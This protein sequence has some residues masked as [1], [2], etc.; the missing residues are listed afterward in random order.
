MQ[1]CPEELHDGYSVKFITTYSKNREEWYVADIGSTLYGISTVPLYESLS[2]EH[3][4]YIF[5]QTELKTIIL[6]IDKLQKI[7]DLKAANKA[8]KLAN[9]ITIEDYTETHKRACEEYG[10]CL[11]SYQEII[12]CGKMNPKETIEPNEND[13]YTISYTSGTT[14][15]PKGVMLTHRNVISS[16][17]IL[18]NKIRPTPD[19]IHISFLPGAHMYEK[20]IA[21]I[22]ILTGGSIGFYRG[23]SLT[24][25]NDILL[26]K[27]TILFCVPRILNKFYD[28]INAT[29]DAESENKKRIIHNAIR[30]KLENLRKYGD[31]THIIYDALLFKKMKALIGGRVRLLMSG[32]APMAID[33]LDFLK[34]IFSS[35]I[36]DGY[37][38]TEVSGACFCTTPDDYV[39]GQAG[40]IVESLAGKLVDVPEMNYRINGVNINGESWRCGEVCLKG[41]GLF[42]KYFK[43]PISTS[44][45]LDSEGWF[46][47]GDIARLRDNGSISVIDRKKSLFKLSQGE[48]ISP[49]RVEN[50]Y[51]QSKFTSFVFAYGD[52]LKDFLVAIIVPDKNV[53]E[54]LAQKEGIEG[55]W[56]EI[57]RDLK[58]RDIIMEDLHHVGKTLGLYGHE[59]AKRIYLHETMITPDTGLLTPTFKMKRYELKMHFQN[60]IDQLYNS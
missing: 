38:L 50:I 41:V 8:S 49:E 22:F 57:C 10:L 42:P 23:D 5:A 33:I 46:H 60:I 21:N 48:Y 27:P 55:N 11:Y 7:I 43:N 52:S 19:D 39:S 47:T 30:E 12:Q 29:I 13:L 34:V 56:E 25:R 1:L 14:G 3:I 40:G 20:V 53:V 36:I 15:Y 16:V 54:S 37:G 24:I 59:Q 18:T 51:M 32:A 58:I 9:I 45:V 6:T 4:E 35:N 44:E 2:I 17:G 31:P 28:L 26:L